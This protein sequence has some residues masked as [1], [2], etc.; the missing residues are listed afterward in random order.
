VIDPEAAQILAAAEK[1]YQQSFFERAAFLAERAKSVEPVVSWE[2]IGRAACGV[3]NPSRASIAYVYVKREP[4]SAQSLIRACAKH[5]FMF[6]K[7]IF[8]PR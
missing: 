1:A 2:L 3:R 5:G 4:G 6:S 7:G 8:K